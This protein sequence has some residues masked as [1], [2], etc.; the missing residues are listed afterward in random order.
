[1]RKETTRVPSVVIS[2]AAD[3]DHST[4]HVACTGDTSFDPKTK[5][6]IMKDLDNVVHI[7]SYIEL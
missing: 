4:H 6:S 7:W 3:H 5:K 1:M 2:N